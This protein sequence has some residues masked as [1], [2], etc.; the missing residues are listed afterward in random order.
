MKA[1][2]SILIAAGIGTMIAIFSSM[3]IIDEGR[4]GVVTHM[5][6]AVRQEGPNGLQFKIPFVQ[7]VREFDVRERIVTLTLVGT[8]SNQLSTNLAISVNWRPDPNAILKIFSEYGGPEEFSTNVLIPRLSQGSKATVGKFSSVQLTQERNKVAEAILDNALNILA[9]YPVILSSVQLEDFTLPPRYWEAV[10]S[11]EEQREL[12]EKEALVLEQ[13]DLQAQQGVQTAKAF[14]DSTVARADGNAY[15][16]RAEAEAEAEAIRLR[17]E[18][19]ADA[20]RAVQNALANNPLYVDLVRA[21]GWNGQLPTTILG[22][23]PNM[24]M[25]MPK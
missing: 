5:G 12:T 25:Q 19:E 17:G 14:R 22:N 13:Q 16:V 1:L 8:T 15:R 3:Y 7:G 21:Q 9:D 11:R 6:Q 23:S 10:I 20:I 24:L 18:A 2:L 4:V